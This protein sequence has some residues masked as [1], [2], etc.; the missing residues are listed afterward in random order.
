MKL[1][2]ISHILYIISAWKVLIYV[3]MFRNCR[4]FNDYLTTLKRGLW[5]GFHKGIDDCHHFDRILWL[6]ID[7]VLCLLPASP[8]ISSAIL[9]SAQPY[10]SALQSLLY[11]GVWEKPTPVTSPPC[12]LSRGF[13][14][15]LG[16]SWGVFPLLHCLFGRWQRRGGSFRNPDAKHATVFYCFL[17][18]PVAAKSGGARI[19]YYGDTCATLQ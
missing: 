16:V 2:N 10:G 19:L 12:R 6:R 1:L 8:H 7:P 13:P 3:V 17:R 14:R 11:M 18:K 9:Q 4:Y 15:V 5:E